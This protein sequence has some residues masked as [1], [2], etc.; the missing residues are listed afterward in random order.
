MLDIR[1]ATLSE[2]Y[3]HSAQA[4]EA[5]FRPGHAVHLAIDWQRLYCDFDMPTNAHNNIPLM[6]NI[7]LTLA[8]TNDFAATVRKSA[9]TWWVYHDPELDEDSFPSDYF[10]SVDPETKARKIA[11]IREQG[12]QICGRVDPDRDVTLRKPFRDAFAGTDLDE[13]LRRRG[14]DTLLIT[15]LYRHYSYN[16]KQ[17]QCVGQT[18]KAAADLGYNTFVVEDLTV[19]HAGEAENTTL[20][21]AR[22][23]LGEGAFSV[24]ADYVRRVVAKYQ[25]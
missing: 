6:Q 13:R 5:V 11:A 24:A 8:R 14:I 10:L 12:L 9:P 25:L 18:M 1:T 15:G 17:A 19:G 4:L 3:E 2:I 22:M 7:A 21:M 16:L 20:G 23:A